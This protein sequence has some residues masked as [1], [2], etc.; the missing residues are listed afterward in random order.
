MR[1]TLFA[2]AL[3]GAILTATA[4]GSDDA[5]EP[6]ASPTSSAT[7]GTAT[8]ASTGTAAAATATPGSGAAA[9]LLTQS[10][11]YLLYRGRAGDTLTSVATAFSGAPGTPVSSFAASIK[12]L[13]QLKSDQ[14]AAGQ[15]LAIP[16]VLTGD[17]SMMPEASF[18]TAIGAG[19]AGGKLVLLQP[20]LEMRSDYLGRLVLH[21]VEIADGSPASEGFGYRMEY[22]LADRPPTK[23]GEADQDAHIAQAAFVVAGGSLVQG[24]DASTFGNSRR[25]TRDGVEYVVAVFPRSTRTADE[26]AAKLQ[27]ARER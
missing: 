16:L 23:G 13:N 5:G 14:I 11:Q 18:E 3:A 9:T 20:S 4:C 21:A 27:T 6:A 26:V 22:W 17:L 25:F 2:L 15:L 1:T 24:F 7:R 12:D 10:P 8:G 19:G